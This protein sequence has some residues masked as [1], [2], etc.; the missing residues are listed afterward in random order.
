M[1]FAPIA[2]LRLGMAGLMAVLLSCAGVESGRPS[3]HWSL[4]P[5]SPPSVPAVREPANVRN[6]IDAFVQAGLE[7]DGIRSSP[8]ADRRTLLRRVSFDLTGL[9]PSVD[10]VAAFEADPDPA[11]YEVRVERLLASP[12]YGERWA[13][14]WLDAVHYGDTHGNDHDYIRPHAWPYRDY[15]IESFNRDKPYARFVLEQIA[16]DVLFPRDPAATVALGF[17]AAGPWD[18][19][20]MVGVNEDTVD[21]RMAQNLDRDNMVTTVMSTFLSTTVQC[22][23][24]HHHKFGRHWHHGCHW[25]QLHVDLLQLHH[26]A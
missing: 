23:R 5:L 22:A 26:W 6:S 9:L 20:L 4:Q 17:L 15:V 16:G 11:A 7:R 10:E 2:G 13:R 21:H 3:S 18:E 8:E 1:D 24:C 12:R 14:H 25:L 19:T